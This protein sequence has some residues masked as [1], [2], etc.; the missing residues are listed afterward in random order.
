VAAISLAAGVTGRR[1]AWLA[2]VAAGVAVL[3]PALRP[4]SLLSLDLVVTPRIPVPSGVWGLGPELPR[5]VPYGVVLAWASTAVSGPL[6]VKALLLAAIAVAFVGAVRL[7]ADAPA[8]ARVGAGLAYALSPFLLTRIGAGHLGVVAAHAVLPWALPVLLRPADRLA[9]TFLWA[10]ALA[11]T[12]FAGGLLCLALVVVGVVADRGRRGL[13]VLAATVGAQAPWLVPGIVVTIAGTGVADSSRFA[14]RVDGFL[15]WL[16]VP[17]GHGF[18]R[19]SSQVGGAG[20]G[21]AILGT[22]LLGLAL[23]GRSR[24]PSAWA[25]RAT[26]AAAAGL[27]LALA[28]A[29]PGASDVYASLT[30]TALGAAVRESHR[31]LPLFL[32]WM[33]PAA[34]LGAVRLGGRV[35]LAV[36][37]ACAVALAAPGL[38][39]VGDRLEPVEFPRGWQAVAERVHARP[40]PVLALPWHQYLDVSFAEGRRVLNPL[41]D[42]L[43]GD[44]LSS[45]DP[46]LAARRAEE[47]DPRER[48][49]LPLLERVAIGEAAG[50]DLA[51]LGVRWVVL[52]HEV[53]WEPLVGLR[54]DPGLRRT[55]ADG[56]VELFEVRAW[57]GPVVTATGRAL[58]A[59]QP[60]A[61]V[62]RVDA[63]G[64]AR[65]HRPAA[66]GWKRGWRDADASAVGTIDLPGGRG[67]VWHWPSGAVLIAYLVTLCVV[68]R[69]WR[70]LQRQ[71][72]SVPSNGECM[73]K[74]T[75]RHE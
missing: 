66:P 62:A 27:V 31:W 8:V 33:A 29:V 5:R 1:S 4:G 26:V 16:A 69:A 59:R 37:A 28:S 34:A 20:V 55:V 22:A 19:A 61:P 47:H 14:T 43:G 30:G 32:V 57:R 46:E 13:A 45:S 58:A 68:V 10:V 24:L 70:A 35:V 52:L 63:S 64:P 25:G 3:G 23:A 38:W 39:G 36:P 51:E 12:G 7:A 41:P 21:V 73:N 53:D 48:H 50:A 67:V 11:C 60:A 17:A 49:V 75:G 6:A 9:R 40:G 65:W 18:W 56:S 72:P 74:Q 2:G 54:A 44:V 15:G 71:E 42:Y